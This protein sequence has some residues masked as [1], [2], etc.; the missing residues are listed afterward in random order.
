MQLLQ[1]YRAVVL[2]KWNGGTDCFIR[3]SLIN[4]LKCHFPTDTLLLIN[5]CMNAWSCMHGPFAH[6]LKHFIFFLNS[7]LL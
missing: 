7:V 6:A 2:L 1:T 4:D 3:I 5:V